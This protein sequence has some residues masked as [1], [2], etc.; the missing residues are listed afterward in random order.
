MDI[1]R[2]ESKIKNLR[3][4]LTY[5]ERS[6]KRLLDSNSDDVEFF[7]DSVASRF[8]ILI[9]SSWKF[10]K[11]VLEEKGF[12]DVPGSPKDVIFK[13]KEAKLIVDIAPS[14]F[15]CIEDILDRIEKDINKILPPKRQSDLV[16][17]S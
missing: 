15:R 3:K 4:T 13:A 8:K 11:T 6:L 1:L 5:L 12:T 16:Y 7:Q 9:E 10:L 14:A 2:L 17:H